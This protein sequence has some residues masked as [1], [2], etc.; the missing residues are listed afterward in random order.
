MR[1]LTPLLLLFVLTA[2]SVNP[3]TGERQLIL[4]SPQQ[5]LQMGIQAY[6]PSQQSQGG[7]YDIDPALNAYVSRVGQTIAAYSDNP[8][9][10]E[11]VVLN[12]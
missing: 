5:E 7:I 4:A 2:C 10:Y 6:Q 3:V 1:H 9:P 12:N 8:L 11:F